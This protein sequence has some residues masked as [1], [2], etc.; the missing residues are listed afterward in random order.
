M[1]ALDVDEDAAERDMAAAAAAARWLGACLI[2][3][4]V[5][6]NEYLGWTAPKQ[7]DISRSHL[8]SAP[9]RV[10]DINLKKRVPSFG[11]YV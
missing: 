5:Y 8:G 4:H 7:R 10:Q 2:G 6:L 1:L 3:G 11:I 9:R